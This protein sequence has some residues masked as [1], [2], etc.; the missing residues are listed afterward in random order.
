MNFIDQQTMETLNDM[1]IKNVPHKNLQN[2]ESSYVDI[3]NGNERMTI[4]VLDHGFISMVDCMPRLVPKGKTADY[5]VVQAA[6]VSYGEGTKT[7]N[8]D[9]G[10]I[11]YLM[12]HDHGTPFEMV[13]L[14]FHLKM[15]IFIARQWMRH[16]TAC[17]SGDEELYFDFANAFDFFTSEKKE[18]GDVNLSKIKISE[19][20]DK[21]VNGAYLQHTSGTYVIVKTKDSL[22]NMFLRCI[23]EET[24]EITHT[25]VKD[26]W[27]SGEKDVFEIELQ[28]GK[29]IK[30]S[31][32]HLYFTNKGWKKLSDFVV[33]EENNTVSIFDIDIE[34]FSNG[35]KCSKEKYLVKLNNVQEI[36]DKKSDCCLKSTMDSIIESSKIKS[37][38]HMGRELTYD[39][40]VEGS[41]HNFICNGI[42]VHNSI[43]E[44]SA[45]YSQ[46]PDLYYVPEPDSLKKQH[47]LSKQ[48]KD[49]SSSVIE[50]VKDSF[51][52]Y[53]KTKSK[54]NHKQYEKFMEDGIAREQ[55]RINLGVN[56]YTEFYWKCDLR[57]VLG[58]LK[59]RMDFHAQSE[60]R[61]YAHAMF[62]LVQKVCPVVCESFM[63]YKM[64]NIVLS[65]NEIEI[66]KGNKSIEIIKS[67][68][69]KEELKN[70]MKMLSISK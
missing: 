36:S 5:A 25:H 32:D 10:L 42:V 54:E 34:I 8:A 24:K 2:S 19:F 6:R 16:R 56:V 52:E 44:Y 58:F 63:N 35:S 39:L 55:A 67:K 45:R 43:N 23:N 66:I 31:K 15:P 4:D 59:L 61:Q 49:E 48:C 30:T 37:I 13:E 29:K 7:V 62:K 69:E 22:K 1:Q 27:I 18:E 57:N 41:F 68:E 51:I 40:E 50:N 20:Y 38:K 9:K 46:V 12:R 47:V 60:I 65:L 53:S 33:L 26:I 11:R 14:K 28:N 17:I 70:K 64:N 21:W 3:M